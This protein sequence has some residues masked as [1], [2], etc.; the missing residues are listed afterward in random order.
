[1]TSN[2]VETRYGKVRGTQDGPVQVWKGIPFARPPVGALRFRPPQPPEPWSEV[3][4]ATEFSLSSPQVAMPGIFGSE[5][6]PASEDCLYLNIWSPAADGGKRP[7]LVWIHGGA[8]EGGSGSTPW[9]DG[10]AFARHGDVVVVTINYRLGA[11]GFLYLAESGGEAYGSS[12]NNGILDQVAALEWVR[13]NIAAFGG[14]PAR[15]TVFGESAGAMSIGTL[16]AMPAARGLFQQAILQSGAAHSVMDREKATRRAQRFMDFAGA[17]NVATLLEKPLDALLDA[18]SKLM[19]STSGL[20]FMPV[21]DGVVLPQAPIEAITA[22]SARDVRVLIGSNRD[23]WKLFTL[24]DHSQAEVNETELKATFGEGA[25]EALATYNA[26]QTETSASTVWES[27]ITDRTFRIPALRVAEAQVRQDAPVWVYR[28]D[29]RSPSFGGMLGAGHALEIVFVWDN[30]DKPGAEFFTGDA[31]TR[32][33]LAERMHAAWIAFARDGDPI[34]PQLPPWPAYNLQERPTMIFDEQCQV[35][36]DPQA[37]E[38][39][40]WEGV[41]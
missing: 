8:F 23:E 37:A 38:R 15:V 2:I 7:V 29:W 30:L 31:P 17:D 20:A 10:S 24:M 5:P 39:K 9:Y 28:F 34:T 22:G 6:V 21:V 13:D 32:Q 26:A 14:D 11:L 35:E 16:L 27:I 4:D 33:P 12:G 25:S 1:M 3:R 19:K 18:Q 40:V 41:F 36:N